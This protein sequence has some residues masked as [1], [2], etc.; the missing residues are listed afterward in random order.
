M[1]WDEKD[2]RPGEVWVPCGDCTGTGWAGDRDK[3]ERQCRACS[4]FG[5]HFEKKPT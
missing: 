4:G 2:A 3:P 1:T 5:G